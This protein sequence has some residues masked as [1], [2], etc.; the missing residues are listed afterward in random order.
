MGAVEFAV[1]R[2]LPLRADGERIG[3]LS[4]SSLEL[5]YRCPERWRRRYIALER[6]P[7]SGAQHLGACVDEA[8]AAHF[9][10]RLAGGALSEADALDVFRARWAERIRAEQV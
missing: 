6:P 7:P 1:P 5:L 2:E 4:A 8:V 10:A 9:R 3:H